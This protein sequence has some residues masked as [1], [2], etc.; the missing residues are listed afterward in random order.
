MNENGAGKRQKPGI[1]QGQLRKVQGSSIAL[2]IRHRC[3]YLY[4]C[5]SKTSTFV[6]HRGDCV[7][8][9]FRNGTRIRI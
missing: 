5:T 1:N 6:L 8:E 3:Q 9:A 7:A 4:F 2:I